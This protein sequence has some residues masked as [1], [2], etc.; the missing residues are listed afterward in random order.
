MKNNLSK[1]AI[2]RIASAL[3]KALPSVNDVLFIEQA[4]TNIE[5]LELKARVQ[6]IIGVL[7]MH[8][9]SDF[10]QAADVLIA[11]KQHWDYGEQDDSYSVFA[12]WPII[13]YV[14]DYGLAHPE[15]A[16]ATLKQLTELF[17]AEFAIRPF[18]VKYPDYCLAQFTLWVDDECEH[19]RRL[20]S[21][22][23]RPRLP[24][25]LRLTQFVDDPTP[26]LPLLAALN[27]D[28][29]LYV[30]RSVAN[31]LNDIAKDHPELVVTT[32]KS[33]QHAYPN[34]PA[35]TWLI[36]HA[37]RTLVK[38]GN[39]GALSL[40]GFTENPKISVTNLTLSA[41]EIC[42]GDTMSFDFELTAD[43]KA[44][45]SLVIDYAM[46]FVKANGKQSAKVFKIKNL[47]LNNFA[48]VQIQKAHSFKAISTRKYYPGIHSIEI[49][50]NGQPYAKQDFRLI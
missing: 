49:L 34:N 20:V 44:Q 16:L 11:M 48:S 12:A 22:G 45:Q 31:H 40:L 38:A 2:A 25:G 29:S 47:T 41:S 26:N 8:L 4:L 28:P 21:E 7:H 33:W 9:P 3:V 10:E 24:W 39:S 42:Q 32:C 1:A 5:Q 15:K 27:T 43:D 30:R 35:L 37:T 50:I 46:Y 23:T 36:K 18:I 6:H 14:S 13:D 17:S 19:V